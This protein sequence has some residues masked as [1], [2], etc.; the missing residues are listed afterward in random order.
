M[1]VKY[2]AGRNIAIKT[3]DHEYA[4]TVRFYREILGFE[5]A[6]EYQPDATSAAVHFGDKVLWIDSVPTLSQAEIWLEIKTDNT[7]QARQS[8]QQQG[9]VT[10][11][12]IEPLPDNFDGFWVSSPNS[13]IHLINAR[14]DTE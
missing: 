12:A 14:P 6:I 13:I 2:T 11:D 5:D 7:Q 9:I 3:P 4:E 10:R 8:L 1:T